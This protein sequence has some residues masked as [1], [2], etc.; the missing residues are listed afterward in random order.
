MCSFDKDDIDV[1]CSYFIFMDKTGS[2]SLQLY[3]RIVT[4]T[5][6]LIFIAKS[7]PYRMRY[8]DGAYKS[9]FCTTLFRMTYSYIGSRL[10]T[11]PNLQKTADG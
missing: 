8:M 7:V 6:L 1:T 4:D 10:Q 11:K 2:P 5:P 9:M 3:I